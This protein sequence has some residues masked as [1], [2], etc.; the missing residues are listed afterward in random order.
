MLKLDHQVK[1]LLIEH[2]VVHFD[3]FFEVLE[4]LF[5]LR[6]DLL[7]TL[8]VKTIHLDLLEQDALNLFKL[9]QLGAA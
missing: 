8:L 4:G 5:E 1:E 3:P 9:Q 2:L 7:V 6:V